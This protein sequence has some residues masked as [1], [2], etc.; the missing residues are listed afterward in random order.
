MFILGSIGKWDSKQETQ[1]ETTEIRLLESFL[2]SNIIWNDDP[3]F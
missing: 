1:A 3:E 2:Q